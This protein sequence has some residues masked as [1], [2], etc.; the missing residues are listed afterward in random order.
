MEEKYKDRKLLVFM[1]ITVVVG[2]VRLMIERAYVFIL[3]Y[4]LSSL[5][6]VLCTYFGYALAKGHNRRHAFWHERDSQG[7]EPSEFAI[8]WGKLGGWACFGLALFLS[9]LSGIV[10]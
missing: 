4:I 8:C 10:G 2:F 1:T 6:G 5:M 9:L 3:P 7:G